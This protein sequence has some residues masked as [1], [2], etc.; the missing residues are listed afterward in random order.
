MA[1][2]LILVSRLRGTF[3]GLLYTGAE[4]PKTNKPGYTHPN[5]KATEP[6]TKEIFT[7]NIEYPPSGLASSPV[8]V[9]PKIERFTDWRSFPAVYFRYHPC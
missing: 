4:F 3:M 1:G 8:L 7:I 2:P 6:F 5:C 9:L